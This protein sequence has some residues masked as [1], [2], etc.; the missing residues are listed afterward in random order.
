MDGEIAAGT[1]SGLYL[2]D[3]AGES[4]RPVTAGNDVPAGP[5]VSVA[6]SPHRPGMLYIGTPHLAWKTSEGMKWTP[7]HNGMPEDS[8]IFSI[9]VDR[10]APGRIFASAC[11]G[12]YISNNEG[13]AWTRVVTPGGIST[14][15][16][17]VAAHPS[18][19]GQV[20]AGTASGVLWSIDDGLHWKTISLRPARAIAFD[21]TKAG[22][23]YL[24]TD[25]GI[26]FSEDGG[27]HLVPANQGLSTWRLS[28]MMEYDRALYASS[29]DS[30]LSP[31][32]V[33]RPDHPARTG[34]AS[35]YA[36][37]GGKLLNSRDG[38]RVWLH[39][40]VPA[41]VDALLVQGDVLLIACGS[42]LFRA[43]D[44]DQTWVR[45]ETPAIQTSIREIVA[46][47]GD[48]VAA[49]GDRQVLWSPDGIRWRSSSTLPG[50]LQI[51]G[52]AGDGAGML[53]AAT[54]IGLLRSPDWGRT[55]SAV[56][57]ELGKTSIQAVGH[58]NGTSKN[59]MAAAFGLVYT[60]FDHGATWQ[61]LAPVGTSIGAIRQLLIDSAS[62]R[63][64]ALTEE[65][66]VFVWAPGDS[67]VQE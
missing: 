23:I 7:I 16:Y 26:F 18:L 32:I 43:S 33:M 62:K 63:L 28:R 44:K 60:S 30:N 36:V 12:L 64:F 35:A 47:E 52:V 46:L 14:R 66:G 31:R 65:H 51:R 21:S 55:W 38:G 54:T 15:T 13:A 4:W 19:H 9:A 42:A 40:T 49:F 48:A 39:L 20:Y 50:N 8:D 56:A 5:I 17:F 1:E 58:G 11:S 41:R 34:F 45:A 61:R 27:I 6:F 53:L 37:S 59:F 29:P 25:E 57:G 24:A 67:P 2:S 3:D 10:L 22:R